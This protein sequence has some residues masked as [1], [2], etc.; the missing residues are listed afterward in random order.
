MRVWLV[1]ALVAAC[2]L[3]PAPKLAPHRDAPEPIDAAEPPAPTA[4]DAAVE[5]AMAAAGSAAVD[6]SPDCIQTAQQI[7]GVVIDGADASVRGHYE[8][9]RANMVRVISAACTTQGWN[10]DR[11]QCFRLAK[12]DADIRACET[13]YPIPH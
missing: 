10:A 3:R 7:A 9:G 1:L 5:D 13:K 12:V 4:I 6:A 8:Q 2:D 11:Q